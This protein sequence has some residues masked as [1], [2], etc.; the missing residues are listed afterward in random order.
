MTSSTRTLVVCLAIMSQAYAQNFEAA[1]IHPSARTA[2]I[3]LP[4]INSE[5]RGG[6]TRDGRYELHSATMADLIGVA[7]GVDIFKVTRTP[8]GGS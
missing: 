6:F 1:D 3:R 2:G 8:V 5:M 7:W 4:G